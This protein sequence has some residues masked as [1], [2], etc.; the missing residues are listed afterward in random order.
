[1]I[2]GIIGIF[3]INNYSYVKNIH[4]IKKQLYRWSQTIRDIDVFIPVT[5][6]IRKA[7]QLKVKI[8][9]LHLKVEALQQS[10]CCVLV[11]Q[12]FPHKV[13]PDEC[14]WSLVGK[15]VQVQK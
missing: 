5:K 8:D 1:M 2:E 14:I 11:D 15:H 3:Q 6:D 9:S 13:K 12:T 7:K 10:G 4:C